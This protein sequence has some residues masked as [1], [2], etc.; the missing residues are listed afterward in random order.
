M[1]RFSIKPFT[2]YVTLTRHGTDGVV[3]Q[4]VKIRT[5]EQCIQI[6]DA[7]YGQHSDRIEYVMRGVWALGKRQMYE[8]KQNDGLD[9]LFDEEGS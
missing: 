4:T 7:L 3:E 9:M 1:Y 6:I 5:P 2:D 8:S